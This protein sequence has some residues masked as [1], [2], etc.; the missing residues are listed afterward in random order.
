M[1]LAEL[2][3]M[4]QSLPREDKRQLAELLA[5]DLADAEGNETLEFLSS[6][7]QEVW[8]PFDAYE[9]AETLLDLLQAN[10]AKG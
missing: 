5:H 1:S 8:S 6:S 9:A 7:P 4:V 3:P 10:G 2:V